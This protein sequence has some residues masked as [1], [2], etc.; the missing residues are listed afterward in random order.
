MIRA[1]KD[2]GFS[3][4]EVMI[5]SALG[6]VVL[7]A[8]IDAFIAHHAQFR[9]QQAKAEL[10]QD[11]RGGAALLAREL[12]LAG[13]G[14][15]SAPVT[16]MATREVAFSANVN[17]I[18]GVLLA[19]AASGQDRLEIGPGSSGWSKG[20]RIVVCGPPGCEEHV[21]AKDASSSGRLTVADFLTRDFPVGS[22]VE[23]VN[24]V[25]YYLST[26]DPRNHK[27]MREIDKGANPLIEYV[28]NFSL[29]FLK[30]NGVPASAAED[31]RMVRVILQT[32]VDDSRGGRLRR[33]LQQDMRVRAL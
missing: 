22:S 6:M 20:K 18:R 21:L 4:A 14:M 19:A 8:A 3:L 28:E 11:L 24:A 1:N 16:V 23:L 5:S 9:G 33:T 27:L 31:I 29:T 26:S 10:Q 7:G 2:R 30:E 32:S 17:N 13:G 25:R 15:P 12:R